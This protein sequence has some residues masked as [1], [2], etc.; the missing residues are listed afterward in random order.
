[1]YT[2]TLT[3]DERAAIDWI[4]DRYAHGYD[5][6]RL[7][8]DTL[9]EAAEWDSPEDITVQMKESTAWELLEIADECNY[10]WDCCSRD[11]AAKLT[12]FCMKVV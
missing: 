9:P 7:L 8:S 1:M 10:R 5:L 11:L 4:G 12:E 6:Y 2:L 3:H